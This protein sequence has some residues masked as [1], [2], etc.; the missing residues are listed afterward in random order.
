MKTS[1][2]LVMYR[3][4]HNRL[5]VLLVHP[6]GPFWAGKDRGA[7]SIPKGEVGEDEDILE[8]ARREF[9]EETGLTTDGPFEPFAPV[10]Q[11]SGKTVHAWAVQGDFEPGTGSCNHFT[12]EWPPG[13]GRRQRFPEIDRA[14]FMPLPDARRRINVAQAA[15]LDQLERLVGPA[16]VS[17][18][19]GNPSLSPSA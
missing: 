17:A 8:A 18:R 2:G 16:S 3:I 10:R 1:A 14:C 6:G 12:L 7:W 5:E 19:T 11:R 4:R 9:H 15:F 13:S